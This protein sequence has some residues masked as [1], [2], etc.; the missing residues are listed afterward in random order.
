LTLFLLGFLEIAQQYPIFNSA[1]PILFLGLFGN[2]GILPAAR[3]VLDNPGAG[4]ISSMNSNPTLLHLASNLGLD[5][6]SMMDFICLM[7]ILF[8]FLGFVSQSFCRLPEF[9]TMWSLYFSLVQVTQNFIHQSDEL[10]LEAG[11]LCIIIAPLNSHKKRSPVDKLGLIMMR[12]L[13]FRFLFAS[14]SVKLAS[15]CPLWWSLRGLKRHFETMPLPT[16][17]SWFSYYLPESYLQVSTMYV[18]M[19]E[20]VCPWLFFA[21][22]L[23]LRKFAFYWQVFLHLNI[24]ATGNYGFLS[25]LVITLL[26]SLLDDS[27]FYRKSNRPRNWSGM[28][29][30]LVALGGFIF[31]GIKYFGLG[32]RNGDFI[33][34]ISKY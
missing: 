34:R 28:F 12:W 13:L 27:Y 31:I 1:N 17:L 9:A 10:L 14:G 3:R 26:F 33:T 24:I 16:P 19:S 2:H 4:K 21:P 8:S 25:F 11:I 22:F 6:P 5:V 20:L 18:Y 32:F 29:L 15:G 30:T 23:S 7:G